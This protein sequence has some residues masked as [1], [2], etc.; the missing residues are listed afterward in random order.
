[1]HCHITIPR[2]LHVIV[3]SRSEEELKYMPPHICC[4]L[5]LSPNEIFRC[6]VPN[7]VV[8]M[9]CFFMNLYPET[10]ARSY[11]QILAMYSLQLTVRN[12]SKFVRKGYILPDGN[13]FST[14]V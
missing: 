4:K 3:E 12:F 8:K 9:R 11:A 7:V 14:I 10:L 1:M 5:V 13:L 2:L 6:L